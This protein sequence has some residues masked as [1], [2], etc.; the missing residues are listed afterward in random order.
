MMGEMIRTLLVDDEEPARER[1]RRLLS[2]HSDIRIVGEADDGEEA[3]GKILEFNPDLV[4]LDIQMP[5][6]SG[7]E[8]AASLPSPRPRIIFCT[9]FDEYAVEA[10]ELHAI[11][12]LLKPVN[13]TRLEKA[14]GRIRDL[15]PANP[16][17]LIERAVKA[18]GVYP[19]RFLGK[20]GSRYRVIHRR[21]ILFF[22]SEGGLTKLQ[23]R[24]HYFWIQPTLAEMENRLDPSQFLRISR[25]TIVHLNAV[26]EILPIGGGIGKVALV[27]GTELEVSRRRFGTLMERLSGT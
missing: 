27:N 21:E 7:M 11:D 15:S 10:F 20:R 9:A 6:C 24:E 25:S 17:N 3:M 23:T 13:R 8:V 19:D 5:G 2:S 22:A 16:A 4:F 1:M 14:L 26:K 18:G 12:Y